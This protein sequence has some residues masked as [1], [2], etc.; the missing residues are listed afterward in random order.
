MRTEEEMR[1]RSEETRRRLLF[2]AGETDRESRRKTATS[3]LRS[4]IPDP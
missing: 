1:E 2:A 4:L 3:D